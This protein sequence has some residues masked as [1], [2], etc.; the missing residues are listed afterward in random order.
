MINDGSRNFGWIRTEMRAW[1]GWGTVKSGS[2]S[3]YRS[4][5]GM[6]VYNRK[7]D[8]NIGGKEY[9]DWRSQNF[10]RV[11]SAV[12]KILIFMPEVKLSVCHWA[13]YSTKVLKEWKRVW[14][15]NPTWISQVSNEICCLWRMS[16][17]F[18]V[19]HCG[20]DCHGNNGKRWWL[21]GWNLL[22]FCGY[23]TLRKDKFRVEFKFCWA[24]AECRVMY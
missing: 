18:P 6:F 23:G 1:K 22:R 19:S 15:I 21:F 10:R 14:G 7:E 20:D 17:K 12:I 13:K 16:Q 8:E 4:W 9:K 2:I 11:I 24:S 3:D 5:W